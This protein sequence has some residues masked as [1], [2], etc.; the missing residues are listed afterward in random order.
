MRHRYIAFE[1]TRKRQ[2]TAAKRMVTRAEKEQRE[3]K[4]QEGEKV[5]VRDPTANSGGKRKLGWPYKGPATVIR[6][7]GD[8]EQCQAGVEYEA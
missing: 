6:S 8:N 2:E 3:H 7:L 4:C 5:W 1:E